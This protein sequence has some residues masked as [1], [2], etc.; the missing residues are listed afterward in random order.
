MND[1]E[2]KIKGHNLR[3]LTNDEQMQKMIDDCQKRFDFYEKQIKNLQERIDSIK[4]S[5][6]QKSL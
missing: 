5:I 4:I 3:K 6:L 2:I 1:I